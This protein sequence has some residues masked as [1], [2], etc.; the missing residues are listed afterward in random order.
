MIESRQSLQNTD[1]SYKITIK[2]NRIKKNQVTALH[3]MI[4]FL[5][6][7]MGLVTWLVPA[8]IK[9]EQFAF[10]DVAGIFYS[11][12]GFGLI[13]V[14][15]FLN[16]KIIQNPLKNQALRI[17]EIIT[18][19]S[20]LAYTIFQKWYLPL[21]YSSAALLVIVF[22]YYWEK[23]ARSER[24]ISI[25]N[26]GIKV[27]GFFKSLSL[28]WQ[29]IARIVLRHAVL[30]VDCHDNRLYQFDVSKVAPDDG[31]PELFHEFCKGM[32]ESHKDIP[33]SDW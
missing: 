4:G 24:V 26:Q 31:S 29:D 27:P 9:T 3:L 30:T 12:F 2:Q 11:A 7:M 32:I 18:L 21:G 19:L 5:L 33:K 20:I 13:I 17:I 16:R 14:S 1:R 15:I 25:N 10:L 23:A 28:Q 8:S 6:F 22:A